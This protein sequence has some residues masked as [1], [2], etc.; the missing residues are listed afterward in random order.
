M[1]GVFLWIRL[2]ATSVESDCM[3]VCLTFLARGLPN[4]ASRLHLSYKDYQPTKAVL[5][6][7]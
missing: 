7:A 1:Y 3:T 2:T 6:S 5:P 4:K